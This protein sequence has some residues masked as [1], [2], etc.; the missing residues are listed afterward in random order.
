MNMNTEQR[1]KPPATLQ[2]RF[3]FKDPELTTPKHDEIMLWLDGQMQAMV[4]ALYNAPALAHDWEEHGEDLENSWLPGMEAEIEKA[5]NHRWLKDAD[6]AALVAA[7]EARKTGPGPAPK[8]PGIRVKKIWEYPLR[9]ERGF[10]IGFI[11]M[12]VEVY[13]PHL[14][15]LG[16]TVNNDN[17]RASAWSG[18]NNYT[19]MLT[20]AE[21]GPPH[22][23][24][25]RF[26]QGEDHQLYFEVKP[27]IPSLGE[28][29]RQ[30]RSYGIN[31]NFYVVSPDDRFREQIEAQR[32]GFI[33]YPG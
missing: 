19:W 32:V 4:D 21:S 5:R 22:V 17:F 7:L 27:S 14:F 3:G 8:W 11:D 25:W 31:Q 29:L 10:L 6:K 16:N 2:E 1:K 9:T 33:K 28:L 12:K 26:L 15:Y 18:S 23:P 30:I 20:H 13:V 24:K